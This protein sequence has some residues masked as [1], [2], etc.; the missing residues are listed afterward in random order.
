MAIM[1][2]SVADVEQQQLGYTKSTHKTKLL[3]C[4]A[5]A[6]AEVPHAMG[7]VH[8]ANKLALNIV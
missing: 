8:G 5:F 7:S 3:N 2:V 4:P 6:I 1:V